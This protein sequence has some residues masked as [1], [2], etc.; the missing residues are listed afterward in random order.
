LELAMLIVNEHFDVIHYAGHGFCDS[1]RSAGWV[2]AP[3]CLLSAK[4][5][6]RVRQVPRLVFANACF[7]A[8]TTSGDE[9]DGHREKS[10]GLAQ[11]FF[12][13]GI[14]NYIG[15]GWPVGD[16]AACEC[17]RWFYAGVLGL[18]GL[19]ISSGLDGTAPPAT[20]G[21]A[22]RKARERISDIEP[23]TASNSLVKF[24]HTTWGAYQH[25]GKVGDKLLP[26]VNLPGEP[27]S[28]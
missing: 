8:V 12:S 17:A 13:R 2:L 16:A 5:I 1:S 18:R 14:P 19:D 15:A 26:L 25:Y 23:S 9:V 6:F 20:I 27:T 7:S 3:D 24:D 10:V 11:A 21:L 28:E 22:L 4:E